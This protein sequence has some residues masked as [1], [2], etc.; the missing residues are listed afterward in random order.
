MKNAPRPAAGAR[1]AAHP[2]RARAL[3]LAVVA[4]PVVASVVVGVAVGRALPHLPGFWWG[5]AW[6]SAV[7]VTS[8][9]ALLLVDRAARKALPLAT[10]LQLT[11]LFP[12]SAPS[13][14]KLARRVAGTRAIA[15]EVERARQHGVTG[16]RQQAAETILA[17]VGALGDYDSR[18]RGHSERTQLY[19]SMIA[20]ELDLSAEDSGKL[21]WAA[22][23][24]DIGKLRVPTEILNKP[25]K[26]TDEEWAALKLHPQHGAAI[27]EP[28]REWLG[29]W[30]HAIEQHH[31]RWDGK[32]YPYGLEGEGISLSGRVVAVADS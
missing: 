5:L 7:L 10:L 2:R 11:M 20:S 13:R 24:H 32:G 23:I 4:V 26:P 17:L 22:L 9:G 6:W 21:V 1:W 28:L 15:A 30:Y 29:P 27:C 18:T 8:T 14:F 3:R 25:G 16:S 19:V 31:E 12:D